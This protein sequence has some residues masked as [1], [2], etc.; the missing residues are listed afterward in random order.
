MTLMLLSLALGSD[1]VDPLAYRPGSFNV[2]D[3][4]L[5]EILERSAVV[6][7]GVL[8]EVRDDVWLG[9]EGAYT[10]L[11]W[12]IRV[13]EEMLGHVESGYV[14]LSIEDMMP[15]TLN[16]GERILVMAGPQTLYSPVSEHRID[17]IDS[18]PAYGD[19]LV[20][21]A[22]GSMFHTVLISFPDDEWEWSS[23]RKHD[24]VPWLAPLSAYWKWSDLVASV[25]NAASLCEGCGA[26]VRGAAVE[27][28]Q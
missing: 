21:T 22:Y 14:D 16:P 4:P 20:P 26:T 15:P 2:R 18:Y 27:D 1:V 28:L 3:M 11:I 6:V 23:T 19:L 17:A 13:E 8:E 5:Q 10:R 12:R 7:E 25:R 24:A 9:P